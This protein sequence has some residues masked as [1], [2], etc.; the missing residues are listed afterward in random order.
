MTTE[1]VAGLELVPADGLPLPALEPGAHVEFFIDRPGQPPLVRQYS[2][3]NAPGESDAFVFGV[4][5]EPQSRGGSH[6]IHSLSP[7]DKVR[8]GAVRN[9]FPLS[10]DA[11]SHVLL[12]GGIGITPVLAMAQ[13]L[14]SIA[15]D[16]QVHYF[17]RGPEHVAF[18]ERL[19]AS[20]SLGR[21]H[22]HAGLDG[23]QVRALLGEIFARPKPGAHAYCCGPGVFMD[24]V[25]AVAAGEWP[26]ERVHFERFQAP[27]AQQTTASDTA[28][29]VILHKSGRRCHVEA[30]QSIVQALAAAGCDLM[31]SCEQGV[32]GTC[33][34][35]VLEGTPDHRDAYLSKSERE[36]GRL[37]LPCVSRSKTATLVLDL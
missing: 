16:Y 34:S 25:A 11:K 26:E 35:N 3:C 9:L 18:R 31:T 5:R 29:D 32:C 28:F 12:A 24:T 10:A 15:A 14:A 30:G 6:W 7:G 27:V 17:V 33:L 23:P 36:G 21:L 20:S 4:K 37:I 13:H 1:D 8:L 19:A 2:V 22:V